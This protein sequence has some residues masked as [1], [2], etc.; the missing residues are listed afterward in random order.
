M[1]LAIDIN[2]EWSTQYPGCR[3]G[4]FGSVILFISFAMSW[5]SAAQSDDDCLQ[6]LRGIYG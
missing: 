2:L 5:I 6:K 1:L 4:Q 3:T